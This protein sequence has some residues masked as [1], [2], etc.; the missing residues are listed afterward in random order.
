MSEALHIAGT[1]AAGPKTLGVLYVN[2]GS[3][4]DAEADGT[5]VL[6]CTA[7]EGERERMPVLGGARVLLTPKVPG[8][9]D[10]TKKLGCDIAI[11]VARRIVSMS[12]GYYVCERKAKAT[13]A[14]L[15]K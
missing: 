10:S 2:P 1:N 14:G 9:F 3:G 8:F 4:L 5:T 15:S 13:V 6:V 12:V 11:I 7:R